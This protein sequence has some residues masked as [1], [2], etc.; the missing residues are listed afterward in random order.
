MGK[1]FMQ[2]LRIAIQWSF[3]AFMLVL[4]YRFCQFV[5][6]F[7]NAAP[8]VSRPD[9]VDGFLPIAALVG[10][11]D[12]LFEGRL[13]SVHP[14]AVVVL[15]TAVIV[16]LLLK[17][18][19]CSWVCPVGTVEELLWK[20]G[21]S[22]FRRNLHPPRWLDAPLRGIKY[23]GLAFFLYFIF[24]AMPS[25]QVT[26][27]V[28]SD[29][30][31]IAD[32]RLLDFFLH[33]SAK[34]LIIIGSFALLSLAL[35]NPFCRFL[36]PYGALLGLVSLLSPVKVTRE[37]RTCVSCGV[38]S[39]VCPSHIPVMAKER[40]HSPECIGCWRCIS[41][42]HA[43]GA[44]EMKLTGKKVAVPGLIF[45]LLVV[46]IFWG[47]SLMGKAIGVWQSGISYTEY[48]RLLGK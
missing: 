12:W 45:A 38:C 31:K 40:V 19:F 3:L 46:L 25:D 44:L 17:R 39:Q 37:R 34:A 5:G 48:V 26:A 28:N 15:L 14:A 24:V 42:C 16:A 2:P 43:E 47:G 8:P 32:V 21:F 35:R 13:N 11:R 10:I 41:H 1:R 36:C 20:G 33:L 7:R 9:G 18:S 6:H 30:Y 27:F 4:G 23:L 22:L 29:Y